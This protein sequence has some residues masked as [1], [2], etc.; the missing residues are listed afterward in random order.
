MV[1]SDIGSSG[2]M[3]TLDT[4][5]GFRDVV[6][7][8][9]AYGLG[10][11]VVQGAVNPDEFY[12]FKPALAAGKQPILKR[13]LGTKAIKMVYAQEAAHGFFTRNVEVPEADRLHFSLTDED[14]LELARYGVKIERHYS[15]GAGRDMPMDIEWAKDGVDGKLYVVQARPE[16]VR[17]QK[18]GFS[19]TEYLLQK[20]APEALTHG[21]CVGGKIATGVARVILSASKLEEFKKGEILITEMTDPDWEPIMK[22]ASAIITAKG[23]RTSHAAIVSREL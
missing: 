1:R 2:V 16:T 20:G 10:E 22:M 15:K 17:S 21:I 19:I 13:Q 11:N 6:F 5:T 8:T 18:K 12:V 14:V 23:G 4:E 3:F 7:I 9:S